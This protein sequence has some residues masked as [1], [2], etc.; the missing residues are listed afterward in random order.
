MKLREVIRARQQIKRSL[1]SDLYL[2]YPD[3]CWSVGRLYIWRKMATFEPLWRGHDVFQHHFSGY[4]K[5]PQALICLVTISISL[6]KSHPLKRGCQLYNFDALCEQKFGRV[7]A[8]T[9][10]R[11]L[12]ERCTRETGNFEEVLTSARLSRLTSRYLQIRSGYFDISDLAPPSPPQ[13]GL[14]QI[15]YKRLCHFD[16]IWSNLC[17]ALVRRWFTGSYSNSSL[18]WYM[19]IGST[20]EVVRIRIWAIFMT[21]SKSERIGY[22]CKMKPAAYCDGVEAKPR[23]RQIR[24]M[25]STGN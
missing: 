18:I 3:I 12:H 10:A 7:M 25:H 2:L 1:R 23:S 21:R 13:M 5:L 20:W 8:W 9:E 11:R 16:L 17:Q 4:S 22:S 14:L 19:E 24:R 6:P 15:R